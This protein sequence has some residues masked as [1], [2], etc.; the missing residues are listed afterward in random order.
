MILFVDLNLTKENMS[1]VACIKSWIHCDSYDY[2]QKGKIEEQP[3]KQS[4]S[5]LLTTVYQKT[6]DIQP[7]DDQQWADKWPTA[8][9]QF[10]PL[11]KRVYHAILYSLMFLSVYTVVFSTE[12]SQ[13]VSCCD[14]LHQKENATSTKDWIWDKEELES[15]FTEKT[16]AI[17]IN[18]PHNPIGKVKFHTALFL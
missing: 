9:L 6:T 3:P 15:A 13:I 17:V 14:F 7:T 5:I 18:T 2:T 1:C 11:K 8:V 4:A 16:R 12:F 10:Y